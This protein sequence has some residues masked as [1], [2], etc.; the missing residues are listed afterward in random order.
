M[1]Q[2]SK[3]DVRR[4]FFI[5]PD[6]SRHEIP[7]GLIQEVEIPPTVTGPFAFQAEQRDERIGALIARLGLPEIEIRTAAPAQ[8][9]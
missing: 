3:I 6:G 1:A 8:Q 5:R 2:T 7:N 9:I 4:V